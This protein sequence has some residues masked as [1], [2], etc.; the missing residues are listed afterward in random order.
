MIV[1]IIDVN[2]NAPVFTMVPFR[3]NLSL[4]APSGTYV[5]RVIAEDKDSDNNGQ[6]NYQ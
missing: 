2:D 6:V 1:D 4:G 3:A 5:T